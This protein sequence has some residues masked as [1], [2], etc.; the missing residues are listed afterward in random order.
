MISSIMV[1]CDQK[2]GRALPV[3][4]EMISCARRIA[5]KSGAR[6]TAVMPSHGVEAVPMNGADLLVIDSPSLAEYSAEAWSSAALIAARKLDAQMILIADTSR[7]SD[8]APH[9]AAALGAACITSVYAVEVT[10]GIPQF[11]RAGFHAKLDMVYECGTGPAVIT[12]LPGVFSPDVSALPCGAV[13]H[14]E[15]DIKTVAM[16]GISTTCTGER[17]VE[18]DNAD[19]IISAGRGIGKAE[20]LEM[21]KSMAALFPKSAVAGSRVACDNGWIEHSAQV[22]LTGRTVSPSLYVACGISGSPQHITGMKDSKTVVSINRD[23]D[24]AIFR[25]SDICIVDDLEKFLPA[26]IAEAKKHSGQK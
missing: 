15:A 18:L 2:G 5:G 21:I 4:L 26:F 23:P 3:S 17:N 8:Y 20:N 12:L 11:R 13:E 6:I 10:D 19:V 7:G 22:G 9:V 14:M 24:A 1:M 25:Y 16:S